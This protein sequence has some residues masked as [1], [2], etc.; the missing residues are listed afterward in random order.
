MATSH[1]CGCCH[2]RCRQRKR[3]KRTG[4]QQDDCTAVGWKQL[5]REHTNGITAAFTWMQMVSSEIM[6]PAF[7]PT[8][9]APRIFPPEFFSTVILANPLVIPSHLH[10]STS[11][12]WRF[13]FSGKRKKTK[14]T[15]EVTPEANRCGERT[16]VEYFLRYD[17]DRDVV[18]HILQ[19]STSIC[20]KTNTCTAT[21]TYNPG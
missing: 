11:A 21:Q 4:F 2:G 15:V 8:M 9:V 16:H 3:T 12:S 17:I 6:L 1:A 20:Y 19:I 5:P 10:R 7:G 14:A 18:P 13:S